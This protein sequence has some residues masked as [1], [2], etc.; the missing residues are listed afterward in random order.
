MPFRARCAKALTLK[1]P[2]CSKKIAS[3]FVKVN[4]MIFEAKLAKKGGNVC[5][6]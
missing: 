5:S 6:V 3:S 4:I 2:S 1:L